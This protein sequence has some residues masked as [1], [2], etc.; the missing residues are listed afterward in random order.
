MCWW[1]HAERVELSNENVR[2]FICNKTFE[3]KSDM[4][5]HRKEEH[6]GIIRPCQQFQNNNCRFQEKAC[7]HKHVM[8]NEEVPTEEG[9]NEERMETDSV[10][11]TVS[12]N[13]DNK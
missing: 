8:E 12:G 13:P 3:R 1:N 6:I 11:R 9:N 10:F 2:C 4:M 7:W 5:S